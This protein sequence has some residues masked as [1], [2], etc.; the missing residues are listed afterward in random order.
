MCRH[1]IDCRLYGNAETAVRATVAIAEA[2][3]AAVAEASVVISEGERNI[4]QRFLTFL[5]LTDEQLATRQE[6]EERR[7]ANLGGIFMNGQY[8]YIEKPLGYSAQGVC[9]TVDK[10]KTADAILQNTENAVLATESEPIKPHVIAIM[11][12]S[13]SDL[14][15]LGDFS[16]DKPYLNNFYSYTDNTIRGNLYVSVL[17]GTTCNSE[18][19]FLTGNSK[20]FFSC[21]RNPIRGFSRFCGGCLQLPDPT[22]QNFIG[23]DHQSAAVN[24]CITRFFKRKS[25][26]RR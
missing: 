16:A 26:F 12:E 20:Y 15:A 10:Y 18:F 14:A 4:V 1:G 25:L 22:F 8:M 13:F 11:N 19:E 17:G 5:R 9:E 23:F 21:G 6:F 7:A 2:T 24:L 3:V